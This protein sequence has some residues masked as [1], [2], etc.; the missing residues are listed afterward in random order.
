MSLRPGQRVRV[1]RCVGDKVPGVHVR[2]NRVVR[3]YIRETLGELASWR[4]QGCRAGERGTPMAAAD[5]G[6]GGSLRAPDGLCLR[7]L[8]RAC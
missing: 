5:R 6:T 7:G 2:P 3:H 1:V 4:N 8:C